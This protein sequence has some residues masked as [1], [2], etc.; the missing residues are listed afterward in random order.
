[1]NNEFLSM[2]EAVCQNCNNV[3]RVFNEDDNIKENNTLED[4]AKLIVGCE[5]IFDFLTFK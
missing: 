5:Q 3:K 2:I 1:M 4:T